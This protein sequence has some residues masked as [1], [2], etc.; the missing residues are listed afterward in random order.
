MSEA[1][2]AQISMITGSDENSDS[3]DDK[4]QSLVPCFVYPGKKPDYGKIFKNSTMILESVDLNEDDMCIMGNVRV[5]FARLQQVAGAQK[6]VTIVA[7][8]TTDE[9][10]TSQE[11]KAMIV[12]AQ[13]HPALSHFI[14][15]AMRFY[16]DCD[17]LNVGDVLK[18]SIMCYASSADYIL[19]TDDN[20]GQFYQVNCTPRLNVWAAKAA[21]ELKNLAPIV[22]YN[23]LHKDPEAN[24][25]TKGKTTNEAP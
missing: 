10:V 16:I 6:R 9:W 15:K 7:K 17:D 21:Q 24:T 2:K 20:E 25:N 22:K 12:K 4:S 13:P 19:A 18:F 11:T 8:F 5:N 1:S 14:T 3:E 23:C